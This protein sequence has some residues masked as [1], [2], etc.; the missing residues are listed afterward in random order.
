MLKYTFPASFGGEV[1]G[2]SLAGRSFLKGYPF[3]DTLGG[4]PRLTVHFYNAV[5]SVDFL[6]PGRTIVRADSTP[7]LFALA[8]K[9][10]LRGFAPSTELGVHLSPKDDENGARSWR[11]IPEGL[12][13]YPCSTGCESQ[14]RVGYTRVYALVKHPEHGVMGVT[15]SE[16]LA[17]GLP[18][19][20]R[21]LVDAMAF[22]DGVDSND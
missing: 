2:E 19:V 16:F 7:E 14:Y 10:M 18:N 13:R 15:Q 1:E 8:S 3:I 9:A 17:L 22:A 5:P 20:S 6:P 4:I 21:G 11:I 12:S